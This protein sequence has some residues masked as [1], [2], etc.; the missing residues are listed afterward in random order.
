MG[1]CPVHC[2][3][4]T[5]IPDLYLPGASSTVLP[6]SGNQEMSPDIAKRPLRENT[7]GNILPLRTAALILLRQAREKGEE[8][9]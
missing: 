1:A 8:D 3:V 9:K 5:S 4:F 7:G 2:M 6:Q